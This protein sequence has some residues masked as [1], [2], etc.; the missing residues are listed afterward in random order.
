MG[1]ARAG[2]VCMAT[3]AACVAT[4]IACESFEEVGES[5]ADALVPDALSDGPTTGDA[6]GDG[7][8]R[9]R[10]TPSRSGPCKAEQ[11]R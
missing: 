10:A 4:A 6:T 1:R 2:V 9:C 7:P 11:R 3:L 5:P 8:R